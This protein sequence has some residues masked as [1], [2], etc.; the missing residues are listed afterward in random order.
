MKQKVKDFE[1]KKSKEGLKMNPFREE[2]D[3]LKIEIGKLDKREKLLRC[4]V[5]LL[6]MKATHLS[7]QLN[8]T[9]SQT[10]DSHLGFFLKVLLA[11][12][13]NDQNFQRGVFSSRGVFSKNFR[14]GG[15]P[16]IPPTPYSRCLVASKSR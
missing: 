12:N 9:V 15:I 1:A 6:K 11:G 4:E 13:G 3:R 5:N 10:L 2:R 8:L 16:K 7:K 14:S